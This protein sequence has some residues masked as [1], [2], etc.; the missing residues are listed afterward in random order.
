MAM[1]HRTS[2]ALDQATADRLQRLRTYRTTM[3]LDGKAA[4]PYLREVAHDRT[5]W[6][7]E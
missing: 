1:K 5:T 2:F 3:R 6:G 4:D 7:P